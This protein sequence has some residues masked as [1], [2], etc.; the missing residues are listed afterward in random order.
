[1]HVTQ[2]NPDATIVADLTSADH[3]P[4]D[5]FDCIIFTQSLQMIYDMPAALRHIHLILK[6]G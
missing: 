6:P 1:M 5:T 3:V 2:G 4:S